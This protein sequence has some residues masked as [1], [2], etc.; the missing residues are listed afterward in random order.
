MYGELLRH[1]ENVLFYFHFL[2]KWKKEECITTGLLFYTVTPLI[3]RIFI[4][5]L[6]STHRDLFNNFLDCCSVSEFFPY[7][8]L[9]SSVGYAKFY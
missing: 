2:C 5:A 7:T 4:L 8:S 1:L 9:F 6:I 3:A